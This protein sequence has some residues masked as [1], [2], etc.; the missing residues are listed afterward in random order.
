MLD[1]ILTNFRD[2]IVSIDSNCYTSYGSSY[3]KIW[4][5]CLIIKRRKRE[6]VQG[7]LT[8]ISVGT[9]SRPVHLIKESHSIP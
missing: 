1:V 6:V 2:P 3:R 5:D 4:V 7:K 8:I 9:L